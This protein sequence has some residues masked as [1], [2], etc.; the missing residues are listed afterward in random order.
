MNELHLRLFN[1]VSNFEH[2]FGLTLEDN[3]FKVLNKFE[4]IIIVC[5]SVF[6]IFLLRSLVGSYKKSV[7]L[8]IERK[9]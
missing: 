5:V 8:L 9:Y 3:G 4:W 6:Y 7:E 2:D 1:T